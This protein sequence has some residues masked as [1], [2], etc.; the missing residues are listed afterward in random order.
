MADIGWIVMGVVIIVV[1]LVWGRYGF[2]L[3]LG[4][5]GFTITA[6]PPVKSRPKL[7]KEVL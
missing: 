6:Q 1:A 2:N 3:G 5:D 7:K 4:P